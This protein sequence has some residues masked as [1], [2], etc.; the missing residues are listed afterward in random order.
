MKGLS[1]YFKRRFTVLSK[2]LFQETG[3][4]ER[5]HGIRLE[6]KKIKTIINLIEFSVKGFKGH[7]YYIPFRTIFRTAGKVRQVD[8]FNKLSGTIEQVRGDHSKDSAAHHQMISVFQGEITPFRSIIKKK[9][10]KLKAA[11][12]NVKRK[13]F[14]KYLK[15]KKR[16]LRSQLYPRLN[17]SGLHKTRKVI[18]EVLYLSPIAGKHKKKLNPFYDELQELVGQWHDKQVLMSSNKIQKEPAKLKQLKNACSDDLKK[19]KK[20]SNNFYSK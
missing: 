18:K 1:T 14:E 3:D 4:L 5:F 9:Y 12:K 7:K 8:V 6:V 10:K 2:H 17:E 20:L 16:E 13:H 11:L 15:L 19:I